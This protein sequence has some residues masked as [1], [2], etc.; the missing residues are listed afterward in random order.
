[1]SRADE[2]SPPFRPRSSDEGPAEK[3]DF[4]GHRSRL[5]RR[6]LDGSAEALA[7]YELLEYLLFGAKPRGD[8]KPLAKALLRRFGTLGGVLAADAEDLLA[9]AGMG[10]ASVAAFKVVQESARRLVRE[11]VIDR[12]LLASFDA[13]VAYC[14]IAVGHE[15]L[16]QFLLLFLDR[17]NRLVGEERQQRGTVDHTPVY[18]R[19]VVRRALEL[20]ASAIVLVHNH[21]SG[22]PTPSKADVAMTREIVAAAEALG[23]A[24]H[25]HIVI[26]SGGHFSFRS[27]GLL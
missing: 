21:P 16:E 24:V 9:V 25:D 1:M 20:K 12:P 5:R 22:D 13:V 17:K 4:L 18:P 10:E 23:V 26:A 15:P 11:V 27:E 14:R 8:T 19:E 7:D 2:A 3:P 6:L